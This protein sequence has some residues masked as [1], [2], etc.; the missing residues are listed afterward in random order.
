MISSG[1]HVYDWF[2]PYLDD[3]DQRW[4]LVEIKYR[5]TGQTMADRVKELRSYQRLNDP[6]KQMYRVR[7]LFFK[8]DEQ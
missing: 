7:E 8:E 4:Q 5:H 3:Y 2:D 6:S 1:M